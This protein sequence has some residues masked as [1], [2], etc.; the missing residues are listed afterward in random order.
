MQTLLARFNFK[1]FLLVA[2]TID[3]LILLSGCETSWISEAQSIV[4]VLGPAASAA[5]ELLSAFGLGLGANVLAQITAW[6][7]NA[8]TALGQIDTLIDE[9][10]AAEPSARPGILGQIETLLATMSRNLSMLLPLIHVTDPATEAKVV[11]VFTLIR[12]EIVALVDLI[13]V[14][15]AT[16]KPIPTD[17]VIDHDQ[18]KALMAKLRSAKEFTAE[19]NE[20]AGKLGKYQIKHVE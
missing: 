2:A 10:N 9:F 15:K 12:D 4:L 11:A 16:L 6:E 8:Q 17:A 3:L 14:A 5:L 19:F 18:T 1:R 20:R 13:P 7:Q